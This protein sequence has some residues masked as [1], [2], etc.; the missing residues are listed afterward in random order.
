[1]AGEIGIVRPQ[2][3]VNSLYQSSSVSVRAEDEIL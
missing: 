1:L 3:S 2:L